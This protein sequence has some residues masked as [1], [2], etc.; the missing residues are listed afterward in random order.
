[1]TF[2]FSSPVL[3]TPKAAVALGISVTTLNRYVTE[4]AGIFQEGEHWRRRAP[5]PKGTKIFDM[6]KCV[7]RMQDLGYTVPL[8]TLEAMAHGN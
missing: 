1:M 6:P 7:A 4:D 5:H 3:P 2:T 8:E